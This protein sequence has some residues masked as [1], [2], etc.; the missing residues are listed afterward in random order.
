MLLAAWGDPEGASL[1]SCFSLSCCCSSEKRLSLANLQP[2]GSPG[3]VTG[4]GRRLVLQGLSAVSVAAGTPPF[5]PESYLLAFQCQH[6]KNSTSKNICSPFAIRHLWTENASA[7]AGSL[8]W[9]FQQDLL[10]SVFPTL[11][12]CSGRL[13]TAAQGWLR[14][15]GRGCGAAR[16]PWA[17]QQLLT[18][19][20]LIPRD[21][22][23]RVL[24]A[25]F[26]MS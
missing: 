9:A 14:G 25:S 17:Q 12:V 2:T 22:V 7:G 10:D 24:L 4:E 20:S 6:Q 18:Q 13:P 5:T 26:A 1:S 11:P 21:L 15:W 19:S 8:C 23:G 16:A 3:F